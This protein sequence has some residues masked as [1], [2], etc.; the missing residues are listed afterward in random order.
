MSTATRVVFGLCLL[1]ISGVALAG[2]GVGAAH[3]RTGSEDLVNIHNIQ[4]I[5]LANDGLYAPS[6]DSLVNGEFGLAVTFRVDSEVAYMINADRSHYLAAT[7]LPSGGVVVRSDESGPIVCAEYT[8]E[9]I[10]QV[11]ADAELLAASPHWVSF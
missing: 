10:A 5:S 1:V 2:P 6:L 4:S 11:T 8:A 3:A 9:C 7:I